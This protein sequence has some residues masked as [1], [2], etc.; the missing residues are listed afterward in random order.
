MDDQEVRLCV[1]C[2]RAGDHNHH[3]Q[4]RSHGGDRTV[5]VCQ[6]CHNAIHREEVWAKYLIVRYARRAGIAYPTR[7]DID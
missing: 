4:F 7:Y 5:A 6:R 2:W 1:I 3:V